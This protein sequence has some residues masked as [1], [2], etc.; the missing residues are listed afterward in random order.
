MSSVTCKALAQTEF[1]EGI[2][3]AEM[4]D[5]VRM[6]MLQLHLCTESISARKNSHELAEDVNS[7]DSLPDIL[8][9]HSEKGEYFIGS[10]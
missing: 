1:D 6:G 7:D 5:T 2:T 9:Y 4:Y 10:Y 8:S 3:I